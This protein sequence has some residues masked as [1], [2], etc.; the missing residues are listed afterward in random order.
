METIYQAYAVDNHGTLLGVVSLRDLVTSPAERSV[1]EIMNPN[2]VSIAIDDDQEEAARL[3]AKYDLL[4]LPVVDRSHHIAGIITFDDVLDV[5]EEEATEDVQRLGAVE[6]LEQSYLNT[7]IKTLIR[8]RAPWL[9]VL[10]VAVLATRNVLEHY[11]QIDLETI[12]MLMWFVPLIVSAGG[13]AG[14]QSATLIIRALATGHIGVSDAKKI[15]IRELIVGLSLG[16]LLALVGIVSVAAWDSTRTVGMISTVCIA[17]IVVVTMGAL[18]GSG[19]PLLLEKIGIDPAV[20]ST[21]FITSLVDIFG[22]MVYFEVAR[23]LL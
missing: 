10:F 15:L 22:L 11:S 13:N 23:V 4:A 7:P 9:V 20:A 19:I 8:A 5:V 16:L 3:M 2:I 1:D 6:P 14:S 21:P 17:V 18:L 12:Q